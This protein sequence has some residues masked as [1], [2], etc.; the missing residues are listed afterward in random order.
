MSPLSTTHDAGVGDFEPELAEDVRDALAFRMEDLA[1]G[2][3]LAVS[4]EHAAGLM[5]WPFGN[6]RDDR[7]SIV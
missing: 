1:V 5:P 6:R 3:A 4:H 2:L 7:T